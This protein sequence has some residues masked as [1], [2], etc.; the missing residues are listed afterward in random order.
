[1][2]DPRKW[3]Y[4]AHASAKHEILKRYLDAWYSILGR[5]RPPRL[6]ILDGFAGRGRY[7]EGEPGSPLLIYDAAVRAVRRGDAQQVTIACSEANPT[8]YELLEKAKAELDPCDGV[9]IR[10]QREE[11]SPSPQR[12]WRSGLPSTAVASRP[13]SS[14]I[15]TA[16]PACRSNLSRLYSQSIA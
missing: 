14:S 12:R 3:D 16:S 4:T 11:S 10:T 13:S 9:E 8:N 2:D 15:P 5:S 7:N 1:D 6:L